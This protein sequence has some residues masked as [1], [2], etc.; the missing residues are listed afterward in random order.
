M[1]KDIQE[2]VEHFITCSPG[3]EPILYRESRG[4]GLS[5]VEQQVGGIRFEGS[6]RDA[7]RANLELRTA[8][9]V[10]RRLA[11]FNC[12]DEKTLYETV[13]GVD[14]T[15]Y[16]NPQGRFFVDAQCRDSTLDHSQFV[17]QRTKD[18]VVDSLRTESGARPSIAKEDADL[19]I[20]VH[21]WRNR[22]TLS[23][24]TSGDSL[25][26]RG[27]RKYQGYAPLA[28]TIAASV[29]LQS[30]WDRR[31]PLIDPF[32]GSG[33]LLVEAAL[34]ASDTA[35]GIFRSFGF[36]NWPN[37][38]PKEWIQVKEAAKA[39]V[40]I[41]PKL[42]FFGREIDADHIPGAKKNAESVGFEDAFELEAG[43]GCTFPWK[44]GWGATIASNLPYGVRVGN[45]NELDQLHHDFGSSLRKGCAGYN[46]ALLVGSR[47]FAHL[48]GFQKWDS[49]PI[50]NGSLACRLLLGGV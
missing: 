37:H 14:W 13:K 39:R 20:H 40:K 28:E 36:E 38:H 31:A 19:R 29:I 35:P 4:L 30:S 6:M 5:R 23:V 16:L 33:T 24:D 10:L 8:I 49:F 26:K 21:V 44:K 18:G 34:I 1:A 7:W 43:E 27:W 2:N 9:R 46:F 3:L 22:C 12:P 48:L 11:R 25:H 17:A 42:K 32:C 45:P 15:K 50:Q 41:P 47:Q